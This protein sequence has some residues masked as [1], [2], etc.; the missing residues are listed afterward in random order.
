MIEV[1]LMRL[2][3]STELDSI[4]VATSDESH[5]DELQYFVESL[6]YRCTRGS[7]NDVL[8]RY[9]ETAKSINAETIVR[10]TGDCPIVDSA[11]VDKFITIF[12]Q[13][14]VDYLSNLSPYSFPDGLD[15]E[16]MSYNSLE[17]ANIQS[18]SDYDR[19]HV[20]PYIRKFWT[21]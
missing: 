13:S 10:I 11:L 20:T 3:K 21:F 5:D 19:E 6:G 8:R 7:N 2:S 9:F 4:V 12:H 17:T 15:I 16:V 14:N 1:L 18:S